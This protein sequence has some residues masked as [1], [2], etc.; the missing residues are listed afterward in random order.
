MNDDVKY[1]TF[2]E[3][4]LDAEQ[5]GLIESLWDIFG[6]TINDAGFK[7]LH[8]QIGAIYGDSITLQRQHEIYRRMMEKGFAPLVVLGVGSYSYQYVTR[9]THG[10]AVKATYIEENGNAV[11]VC[12]DPKT[13]AKK[14][15]AYGLLRIELENGVYVQYDGQTLEQE[16]QGELRT[17]FKDSKLVL[18]TTLKEVRGHA[19]ASIK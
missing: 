18:E 13:D 16:A 6:G 1:C 2:T 5:K 17:I 4:T 9:D 15:S 11:N 7:V 12:K 14:K 10:S 19:V 8:D 3:M